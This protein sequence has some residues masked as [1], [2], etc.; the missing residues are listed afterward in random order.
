LTTSKIVKKKIRTLTK[1]EFATE[2]QIVI[3]HADFTAAAAVM[4]R[5]QLS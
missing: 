1:K 2:T 3:R 4:G 5:L